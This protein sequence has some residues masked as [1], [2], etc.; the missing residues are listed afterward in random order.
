MRLELRDHAGT[1]LGAQ[2][3][4]QLRRALGLAERA[5]HAPRRPVRAVLEAVGVPGF[6]ETQVGAHVLH[7]RGADAAQPWFPGL[8]LR[9]VCHAA[10]ADEGHASHDP[11]LLQ[12]GFAAARERGRGLAFL[13]AVGALNHHVRDVYAQDLAAQLD[14][15]ATL[16]VLRHLAELALRSEGPAR[17]V[18]LGYA[19]GSL[20]RC[21]AALPHGLQD[22]VARGGDALAQGFAALPPEP[23]EEELLGALR[24]LVAL[25]P[26]A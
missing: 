6:T 21:G 19:A 15:E 18:E 9:E 25:V 4:E 2:A 10:L 16:A 8:L 17:A 12:A 13:G 20:R 14:R 3:E 7:L 5:G 1:G 22:A 26:E 11:A 24:G 23:D